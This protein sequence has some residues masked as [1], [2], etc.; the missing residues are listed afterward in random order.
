MAC[1]DA[2]IAATGWVKDE[3]GPVVPRAVVVV[4]T[5]DI[6][7]YRRGA[8]SDRRSHT[9]IT[10]PKSGPFHRNAE[11][12]CNS[13][14]LFPK[15]RCKFGEHSLFSP[16]I[17]PP[18]KCGRLVADESSTF[19]YQDKQTPQ[20]TTTLVFRASALTDPLIQT[21]YHYPR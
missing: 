18:R 2:G 7:G 4:A 3:L 13:H 20:P 11:F 9:I 17:E 5:V 6:G 8:G 10:E 16:N 14:N 15:H 19:R 1:A 21:I 12:V